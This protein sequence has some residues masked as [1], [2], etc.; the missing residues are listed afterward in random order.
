MSVPGG[1]YHVTRTVVMSL[2]LLTPNRTVNQV[3]EY[4]LAWAAEK[5]SVLIHSVSVESNHFHI[6]LTDTEGNLSDFVQELDRC[7]ARCLLAYY[8]KRFPGRRLDSLWSPSK[9]FGATLLVNANAVL[10]KI[11]YTLTNPVKDGQVADYRK[12]PGFNTR[13]SDWRGRVRRVKRPDYFFK[14][15][16]ETLEYR[17]VP[18]AQIDR[19]NVEALIS[20][21]GSHIRQRQA[22]FAADLAAQGRTFRGVKAILRTNP[23]DSPSTPRPV[24]TLS[25]QVAAGGDRKALGLATK[26]IRAFRT[27]YRQA[28]KLFKQGARAV[29][30]GGTLQMRRRFGVP[31]D[32]LDAAC[33][34]QLAVS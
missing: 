31:C 2:F 23:F 3:F 16:P 27:A 10:D 30:P 4:C 14:R 20:E 17:L 13:P 32:P 7:V 34:C 6:D 11:V 8:R 19:G 12:W 21:V 1:T 5:Y 9:S 15:T 25:P 28:W 22:Q 29:F 33:W 24:G 26:A 18:P